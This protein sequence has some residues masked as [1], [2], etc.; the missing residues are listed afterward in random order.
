MG[1]ARKF[2][3]ARDKDGNVVMQMMA[4]PRS[5]DALSHCLRV[6]THQLQIHQS[7]EDEG[8]GIFGGAFGYGINFENDVFFMKKDYMDEECD[9]GANEAAD[10]WFEANPHANTCYS[11][12]LYD[13]GVLSPKHLEDAFDAACEA[14]GKHQYGTK[15]YKAAQRAVIAAGDAIDKHRDKLLKARCKQHGIPWNKGAAS[16][17][18]CTCGHEALRKE[19]FET[20]DHAER[21]PLEMPNFWHKPSALKVKWYKYIGRDMTIESEPDSDWTLQQ[22]FSEVL[23][24]F[25]GASLQDAFKAHA[26]AEREYSA[27]FKKSMEFAFSEEGQKMFRNI[28]DSSAIEDRE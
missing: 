13:D 26:D 28:F 16:M 21:C 10:A 17:C 2:A 8:D 3:E 4:P 19:Y 12:G 11:F 7:K 25:G 24:S 23:T 22:I 9:C 18:H 5:D 27:Q 6:L 14:R 1:G 20:H 15:E